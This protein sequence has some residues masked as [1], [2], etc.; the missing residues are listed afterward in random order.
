MIYVTENHE[1]GQLHLRKQPPK[2]SPENTG[3]TF[4]VRPCGLF[5]EVRCV[6]RA[7]GRITGDQLV[8]GVPSE[9][10]AEALAR[11]LASPQVARKGH[12]VLE[13]IIKE[14]SHED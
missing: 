13:E 3:R 5:W 11:E 10:E 4:T 8:A 12:F 6:T 7:A 1:S 2:G 9:Q 14:D